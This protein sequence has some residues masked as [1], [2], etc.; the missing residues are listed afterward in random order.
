M[1]G[2]P[3]VP[4]RFFLTP[5]ERMD[6]LWRKLSAWMSEELDKRRERNDEGMTEFQT[7]TLRGEIK[8]LKAI[9][10]LDAERPIIQA[11]KG[12]IV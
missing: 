2:V 3:R 12:D 9:L 10:K 7:A 5:Q 6:P 1:T 4:E 11:P 8:L